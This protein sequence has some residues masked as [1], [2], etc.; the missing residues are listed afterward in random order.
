[1]K[2]I[3]YHDDNDGRCAAAIAL[4]ALVEK[5]RDVGKVTVALL[6]PLKAHKLTASPGEQFMFIGATYDMAYKIADSIDETDELFILD[7]S[8]PPELF[9]QVA[10]HAESVTWIDHHKS[11]IEKTKDSKLLN[12]LPGLRDES[13]AACMLA[14]RYWFPDEKEAPLAVKYIA[15]RDAWRWEYG[16]QTAEFHYGLSLHETHPQAE[17]WKVL[18]TPSTIAAGKLKSDGRIIM[19][20]L[21][22]RF[23]N[24]RDTV[25]FDT[26]I[27]GHSARAMNIAIAGSAAFGAEGWVT[28]ALP[29]DVEICCQYY[30]NGKIFTVSLYSKKGTVDVSELCKKRGGGGHANAAG[31][32]S[33]ELPDFLRR[34]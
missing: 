1:M 18:L 24:I 27:D 14:W 11:A 29:D 30:H 23:K 9:E 13:V 31:F 5:G 6:S 2:V 16:E 19:Q 4:K 22:Q 33:K 3:I 21:G 28:G 20:A 15:D 12:D 26:V 34:E 10:M 8:L 25:A 7:F 17:I 32:T